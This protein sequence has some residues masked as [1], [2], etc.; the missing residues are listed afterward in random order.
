M[1]SVSVSKSYCTYIIVSASTVDE[2]EKKVNE[3]IEQGWQAEG[4]ITGGWQITGGVT[5]DGRNYLQSMMNCPK[6]I[7]TAS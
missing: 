1:K 2:L 7:D 6:F 4:L 3:I 5:Y